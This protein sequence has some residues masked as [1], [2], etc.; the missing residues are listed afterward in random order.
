MTCCG[1]L[2]DHTRIRVMRT[3]NMMRLVIVMMSMTLCGVIVAVAIPVI[4]AVVA[5]T[6]TLRKRGKVVMRYDLL[7]RTSHVCLPVII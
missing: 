1:Y 6:E 7:L 2:A 4:V 3:I 5:S